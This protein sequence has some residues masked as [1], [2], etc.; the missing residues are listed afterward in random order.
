M[1]A[2]DPPNIGTSYSTYSTSPWLPFFLFSHLHSSLENARNEASSGPLG[3]GSRTIPSILLK[4]LAIHVGVTLIYVQ[5]GFL[6][7]LS[8]KDRYFFL[9]IAT[10]LC[11]P[12]AALLELVAWYTVPL[13]ILYRELRLQ[14]TPFNYEYLLLSATGVYAR[15]LEEL[16]ADVDSV[17]LAYAKLN[18]VQRERIIDES[19]TDWAVWIGRIIIVLF[20][21]A[22]S[23]ATLVLAIRR[24]DHLYAVL[25]IDVRNQLM[26]VIGVLAA[27][28]SVVV[29]LAKGKWR[30]NR[31]ILYLGESGDAGGGLEAL[32]GID[33]R[34][35]PSWPPEDIHTLQKFLSRSTRLASEFYGEMNPHVEL[36]ERISAGGDLSEFI[37][38]AEQSGDAQVF[39]K[40]ADYVHIENV[41]DRSRRRENGYI[42]LTLG[43]G[44][45]CLALW[46]RGYS[47][48]SWL[49]DLSALLVVGIPLYCAFSQILINMVC[50]SLTSHKHFRYTFFVPAVLCG[51][52]L[53]PELVKI[54]GELRAIQQGVPYE[55]NCSWA[56]SDPLSELLPIF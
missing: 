18:Q 6:M 11:A 20:G 55:Y 38:F 43:C 31:N 39:K 35:S 2:T 23:V 45:T 50:T 52:A 56:W 40:H 51:S 37:A 1:A 47:I 3:T 22:Q 32:T 53:I 13:F 29:I 34:I 7:G 9:R 54:V 30:L 21:G 24:Y 14:T 5:F 17:P 46:L 28:N 36:R 49:F 26:A 16:G 10:L 19:W 44:Y 8:T 12:I 33:P 48:G 27:C 15:P 25:A 42:F 41:M 4:T